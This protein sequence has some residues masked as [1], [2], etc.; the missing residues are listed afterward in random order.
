M[1]DLVQAQKEITAHNIQL[2]EQTKQL[3][4][5]MAELRDQSLVLVSE[6]NDACDSEMRG[7]FGRGGAECSLH[8]CW[9][10]CQLKARCEEL[11]LDW[12][13]LC[14]ETLLKEKAALRRQ[15]SE[16]QRHCLELQVCAYV[17][18]SAQS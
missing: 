17:S 13:S 12:G 6:Q 10:V 8:I 16:K 7:L 11:K 4:R 5:D 2:R 14:L 9:C 15:I 1:E 18:Q 3:E